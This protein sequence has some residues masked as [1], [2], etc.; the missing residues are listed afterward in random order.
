LLSPL[1]NQQKQGVLVPAVKNFLG[2]DSFAGRQVRMQTLLTR[3]RPRVVM[4][5]IASHLEHHRGFRPCYSL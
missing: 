2:A 5:S 4:L 3:Q 1:T